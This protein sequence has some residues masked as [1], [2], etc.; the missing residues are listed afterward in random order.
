MTDLP[1]VTQDGRSLKR[2]QAVLLKN[3]VSCQV[4]AAV[5]SGHTAEGTDHRERERKKQ[6][7]RKEIETDLKS[8]LIIK[9]Q[10]CP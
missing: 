2:I 9:I 4:K 10:Q 5:T 8:I 3:Q 1:G 7:K 6:G